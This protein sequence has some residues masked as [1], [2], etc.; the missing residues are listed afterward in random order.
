MAPRKPALLTIDN[1]VGNGSP[2]IEDLIAVQTAIL[3]S[4]AIVLGTVK[5]FRTGIDQRLTRQFGE[6]GGDLQFVKGQLE[7]VD[8]RISKIE[9]ARHEEAS[10][11]QQA[12][13]FSV[14]QHKID[15]HV[16]D[17]DRA[18]AQAHLLSKNQRYAI[19]VA[20]CTGTGALLLSPGFAG[21]LANIG[22]LLFVGR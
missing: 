12:K 9:Q 21:L 2:A 14:N 8:G 7:K 1:K 10:L 4:N 6:I 17:V 20:A 18:D 15:V 5:E 13:E 19:L 3:K 16:A 11:T 22:R